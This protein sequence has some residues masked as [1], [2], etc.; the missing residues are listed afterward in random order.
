MFSHSCTPITTKSS[1]R[2]SFRNA[3]S[4]SDGFFSARFH[5]TTLMLYAVKAPAGAG[6]VVVAAGVAAVAVRRPSARW[7]KNSASANASSAASVTRMSLCQLDRTLDCT[8]VHHRA[9]YRKK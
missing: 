2:N 1:P 6:A 4:R 5:V 8:T 3:Q 9:P 7:L